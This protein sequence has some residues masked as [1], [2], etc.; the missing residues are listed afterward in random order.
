M[1]RVQEIKF[2]ARVETNKETYSVE[3]STLT[4][5]IDWVVAMSERF[6]DCDALVDESAEDD[7]AEA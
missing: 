7:E 5:F 4:E 3:A 1:E 6:P 2:S